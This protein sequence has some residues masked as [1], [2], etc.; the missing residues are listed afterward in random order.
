MKKRV[1]VSVIVL[2]IVMMIYTRVTH[3]SYNKVIRSARFDESDKNWYLKLYSIIL[4]RKQFDSLLVKLITRNNDDLYAVIQV[5][6]Y[7]I[8]HEKCFLIEK[9]EKQSNLFH[10]Y[11]K[12]SLINMNPGKKLIIGGYS[13]EYFGYFDTLLNNR[14]KE[15]KAVCE[16][17]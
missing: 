6:D 1:I 11:A 8:D 5:A 2:A 7:S 4:P 17:R 12:D 9:L 13:S 10:S 14:L 15:L 16:N 3:N